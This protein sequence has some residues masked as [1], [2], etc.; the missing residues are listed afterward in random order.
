MEYFVALLELSGIFVILAIGVNYLVGNAGVMFV[1]Q[2]AFF[3]VGAYAT[4]IMT[5]LFGLSPVIASLAGAFISVG[6]AAAFGLVMRRLSGQFLLISSLGLCEIV[7][8][9]VNNATFSGGAQ[10]ITIPESLFSNTLLP[11]PLQMPLLEL[12][13][14]ALEILFFYRLDRSPKGRLVRALR[15]DPILLT[16]LGYS[17]TRIQGEVLI[18]SAVWASIAG[19]LFAH[20]SQYID[21]TS[22]TMIESLMILIVVMIGGVSSIG[23]SV[24]A[25]IILIILPGILRLLYLPSSVVGPIHQISFALFVLVVLKFKPKGILGR[26]TL[27]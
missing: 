1:G 12:A 19:S 3:A 18:M 5:T 11:R 16:S 21:P 13:L 2:I 9:L 25:G 22:F 8:S 27:P 6:I 20:Y 26:V 4:A 17:T 7:R 24:L 15:D 10:G 14:L 23:G